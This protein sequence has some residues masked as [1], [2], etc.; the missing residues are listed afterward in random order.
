MDR[1][2]GL[3]GLRVLGLTGCPTSTKDVW[4]IPAILGALVLIIVAVDVATMTVMRS[5]A[6]RKR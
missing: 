6:R 5:G 4:Y 1:C 3:A 2:L